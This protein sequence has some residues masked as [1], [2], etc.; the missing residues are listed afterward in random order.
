MKIKKILVPVDYSPVSD[1]AV[2]YAIFLA[3][4]HKAS[5]T[6][7]HAVVL[8]QDDVDDEGELKNYEAI[9]KRKESNRNKKMKAHQA[10]GA[11]V[12]VKITSKLIRGISAAES[13]L[14]FIEENK[15][16]LIVMG[17]HGRTGVSKW[18]FGSVAERLIRHSPIPLLSIHGNYRRNQLNKILVPFDFSD[19]SV[20]AA[21]VGKDLAKRFDAKLIFL[22]SIEQEAHPEFYATS[23]DSILRE[24]PHIKDH[25]LAN[26]M[27]YTG[28][29]KDQA[30][31][32]IKEGKA[33]R[34]IKKYAK[35][36]GV[37]LIVMATRGLGFW[38]QVLIGSNAEKVAAIAHCPVL[39]VRGK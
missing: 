14:N 5:I 16:D 11:K 4:K 2:K 22:H 17:T 1:R 8:F 23:F 12:G 33:H 37:S 29:N 15:F 35:D 21:K 28:V 36:N 10:E 7:L 13:I 26:M 24:N 18:F 30:K 25:I 27:K 19:Y 9:I 34:V 3:E 38:D 39:T 31:F 20:T 32:V 6:L